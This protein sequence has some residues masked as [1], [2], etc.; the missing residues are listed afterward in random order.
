MQAHLHFL[1][2]ILQTVTRSKHGVYALLFIGAL[3]FR[4]SPEVSAQSPSVLSIAGEEVN[5]SDFEHI[6]KKNNRAA[7]ITPESL[8]TYME[9]FINF[10]LKVRAAHDL[11]MD[12]AQAF[13]KE[14][15]GYRTQLAR[16]YLTDNQLLEELVL[17]AYARTQE[18]V[19]AHHILI[20][21]PEK[22]APT[23]TLNAWNRAMAMMERVKSGEDFEAM[24]K[25][26]GGSD[27]PSARDNGGDLGWFRAFS[28][29]Y[30]FEDATYNAQIGEVVGPVRTRFGYHIIRLDGRREARGEVLTAH[31][32][33]KHSNAEEAEAKIHALQNE[34]AGGADFASLARK[35]SQDQSTASKGGELPWFGTGRMVEPFEEAAFALAND[36]DI[37]MP[38]NTEFGWHII[39]RLGYKATP[40]LKESR[41]DIEKRISRDSR[42]ELTRR[43]FIDGLAKAYGLE[44]KKGSLEAVYKAVA[45]VDSVQS[46]VVLPKKRDGKQVL[47][48]LNG[49][50]VRAGAFVDALNER[51]TRIQRKD[52]SA[53]EIVDEAFAGFTD[54]LLIAAEDQVL[55]SKHDAFRL[56]MEEYHD[57]ILLFELT[58]RKVWSKA[59]KDS[60]GL[61]NFWD[62]HSAAYRWDTRLKVRIFHAADEASAARIRAV[63]EAGGDVETERR[64]MIS[65]NPLSVTVER[66]NFELGDNPYATE[67]FEELGSTGVTENRM[68]NEQI[69][70]VQIREITPPMQK[71]LDEV[72]GKVIADYQDFLESTWVSELRA[73]Y[74]FTVHTDAL[75]GIK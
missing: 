40:T 12:T 70:F 9:L 7:E 45:A 17:E 23:D 16:P 6:F 18:E 22:A 49:E 11:G 35:H 54:D 31:I 30:A 44:I 36:G 47:L 62:A 51:G 53:Q 20:R 75:H 43:S 33:I 25:S 34:I 38:V 39:Q 67:A 27:D 1:S 73:R 59:V 29:V 24:A 3:G 15:A 68:E 4:T 10:K 69:L 19:R 48:V 74:P 32:M 46:S 55:E 72:R 28:M 57:G 8:D 21:L 52:R 41:K 58:D 56:L 50:K 65:E 5:A 42:S 14:L 13:T 37:S 64:E 66:G 63:V 71:T 60:T 2:S 26:K 61:A